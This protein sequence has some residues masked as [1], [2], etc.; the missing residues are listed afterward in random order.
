[1][2]TTPA[3][4]PSTTTEAPDHG[5]ERR[6][7]HTKLKLAT[8]IGEGIDGYVIGGIGMAMTA[9][10][11]DL[12][13]ST[14]MEGLVGA[15]PLIGIFVGGPLFGR[16]ADRYGRR[17][18]FLADMLIFL[19][20][21][22]LQFF[23]TDGM[24]LFVIRLVMGVAIGGEYAIGAPLLSEYAPKQG[25]GRLLAS[26]E[27]SWYVG[28]A[29][30]TV[31]GA[32]FEDVDGG[33]RWSL[34][35]SAVL[36]V[37]CVSLRGGI[38]ESA[39]WLLSKGRREEA[40]ALIER[41]AIEID[42]TAEI[43]ER[44]A[45]EQAGFGALFS[46][47]HLRST[48]FASVFWAALVLP[49]FAIS[50]YWTQVFEAL[51]MGDNAVAALLVYS[52]TAVAGVTAGCL[53][54]DRIGRRRLLIPP[55]W[56]TAGCLAL[57]AV[58]PSSTPVIVCGFLFFI[59]LNAAS[60]ALTSVYP[61]EVFPT[62]LRATG[63]GF[64]TAMSRVGA[65]IGTFLLPMGLDHYGARFVLL[66]GA[67]VLALGGLVSQFLAPETTDLDLANAARTAREKPTA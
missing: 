37:V 63:V 67:G 23:V 48:V 39:R 12:H 6:R 51:N 13:L 8:Q 58:W 30:A 26:L 55:F 31:V 64:A 33:W 22:V 47:E 11:A 62:S 24:Q 45:T 17:P 14:L 2:A 27:I 61:L 4:P 15:S 9:L 25:R 56:I 59:F 19:V 7:L 16:L 54:V 60:S 65:A 28:Y 32:V 35:S 10:T 53:V 43:D 66:V 52:F 42:V 41:Y 34:A 57:V 49:Y 29:L 36:A 50:T 1:M 40:E 5:R 46:K 38:P 18:V 3:I 20:G 21:S 44:M